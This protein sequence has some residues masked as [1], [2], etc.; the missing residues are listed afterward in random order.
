MGKNFNAIIYTLFFGYNCCGMR[1]QTSLIL[2]GSEYQLL[3]SY[4]HFHGRFKDW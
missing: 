4:D 2:E 3:L 1:D